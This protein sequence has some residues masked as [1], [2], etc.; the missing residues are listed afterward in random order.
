MSACPICS[1]LGEVKPCSGY[2]LNVF[3]G[4]LAHHAD[5]GAEW[6]N[7]VGKC[8][9]PAGAPRPRSFAVY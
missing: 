4:C 3:K 6:D 8:G 5:L 7:Y 2:C 9:C 1:G